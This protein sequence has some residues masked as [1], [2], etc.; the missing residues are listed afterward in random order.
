MVAGDAG[1]VYTYDMSTHDL[2]DVWVVGAKITAVSCLPLEE[3]GFKVAVGTANGFLAVRQDWEEEPRR[4]EC[5][6]KVIH[7]VKFSKNGNLVAVA[8]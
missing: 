6:E 1:V 7:D 8:S 4:K 2:I 3:G 5:G